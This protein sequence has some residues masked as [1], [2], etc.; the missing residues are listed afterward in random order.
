[1]D[2]ATK[3]SGRYPLGS[4]ER[5]RAEKD[6]KKDPRIRIAESVGKGI[7]SSR[8][9]VGE[10][11]TMYRRNKKRP[12]YSDISDDELRKRVNR[13]NLE[14]SYYNLTNSGKVEKGFQNAQSFLGVASD[15]AAIA[16]SA[17]TVAILV[18]KLKG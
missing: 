14:Q 15:V 5:P 10:I 11:E 8:S 18:K 6:A 1:M 4:G 2:G 17:A 9:M 12:N 13:L 3:G 7:N 16:A